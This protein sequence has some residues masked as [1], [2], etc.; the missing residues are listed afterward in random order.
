MNDYCVPDPH[1]TFLGRAKEQEKGAW[2]QPF[3]HALN[4]CE[5]SRQPHIMTYFRTL[6]M[7]I[8]IL[9]VTLSVDL[10]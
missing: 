5:I 2:F 4:R 7:P 10:L 6:V 8:L 3:A 9:R 1:L